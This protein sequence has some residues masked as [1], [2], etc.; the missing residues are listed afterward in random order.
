LLV[1]GFVDKNGFAVN[2]SSGVAGASFDIGF[3]FSPT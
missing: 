2:K 1:N 3:L